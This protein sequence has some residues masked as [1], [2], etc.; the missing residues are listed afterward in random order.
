VGFVTDKVAWDRFDSKYSSSPVSFHQRFIVF[1]ILSVL[2][3]L[4]FVTR[5]APVI[6]GRNCQYDIAGCHLRWDA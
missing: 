6:L 5:A 4:V 3:L 1:G 2:V